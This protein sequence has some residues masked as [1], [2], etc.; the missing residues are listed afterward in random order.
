MRLLIIYSSPFTC[1]FAS[2]MLLMSEQELQKTPEVYTASVN[3]I[4]NEAQNTG[5]SRA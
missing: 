5:V 1:I 2:L 3:N 4:E